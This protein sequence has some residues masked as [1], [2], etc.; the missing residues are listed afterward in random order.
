MKSLGYIGAFFGGAIAGAA[1]GILLA[2]EKGADTRVKITDAID[3]FMKKHNIKLS[4]K[5][6]GDLVD[7]IQDATV[8]EYAMLSSDKNVENIGQLAQLLKKYVELQKEYLK[9]DVIDK[10]VRLITALTLTIVLLLLGVAVLFYLSFACVYWLEPITGT[11]LAFFIIAIFFLTLLLI[12][13]LN[14]KTWIQRPLVRFLA[15]VLLN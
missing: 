9:L 8:E 4:R 1:L 15:D 12:V 11:A 6:V 7:D 3:D 5:E 13:F 2:P 14:R 10:I